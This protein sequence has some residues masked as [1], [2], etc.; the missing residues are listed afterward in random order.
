MVKVTVPVG[1]PVPELGATAAVNVTAWPK[2]DPLGA[3]EL[4]VVVVA[5]GLTVWVKDCAVLVAKLSSP[6]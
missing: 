6:L 5:I 2:L 4:S 1:V 3:D